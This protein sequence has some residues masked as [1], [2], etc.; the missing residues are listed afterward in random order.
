MK[1]PL[2]KT[3]VTCSL[4]DERAN[5]EQINADV[6][7]YYKTDGGCVRF[8]KDGLTDVQVKQVMSMKWLC[9]ICHDEQ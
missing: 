5:L 6:V 4:C 9:E 2:S 8:P 3:T 7:R 1:I